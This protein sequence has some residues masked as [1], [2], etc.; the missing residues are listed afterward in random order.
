MKKKTVYIQCYISIHELY[1]KKKIMIALSLKSFYSI[2]SPCCCLSLS[3]VRL[4]G[5]VF[6]FVT[7]RAEGRELSSFGS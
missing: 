7:P 3:N 1:L 4:K 2:H 5:S 6:V